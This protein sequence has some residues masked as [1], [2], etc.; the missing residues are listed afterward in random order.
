MKNI[1]GQA[2]IEGIL[3]RSE[4]ELV[5]AIR[6]NKKIILK[7]EK[8]NFPRT[9]IPFL[10]GILTLIEMLYLGIKQIKLQFLKKEKKKKQKNQT[11]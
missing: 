9:K 2:L 1:G 7:K 10:R 6:K 4:N 3:F 8:I 11:F 5:I